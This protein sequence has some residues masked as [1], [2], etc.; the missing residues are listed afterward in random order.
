MP[1][2]EVS[3]EAFVEGETTMTMIDVI[4]LKFSVKYT[5]LP[6]DQAPGYVHS[7]NFP[8]LKRQ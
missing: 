6:A 4:M 5:Q 7:S 2:V 3:A 1:I 8:Y